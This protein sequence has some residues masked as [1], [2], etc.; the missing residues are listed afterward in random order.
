MNLTSCIR[1]LPAAVLLCGLPAVSVPGATVIANF[2]GGNGTGSVDAYAGTAGNGWFGAWSTIGSNG[3]TVSASVATT[4]PLVSGS[5]NYLSATVNG[6][7]TNAANT[8]AYT[9]R[10]LDA[11]VFDYAQPI[12]ISFLFR[13]DSAFSSG[14]S[15]FRIMQNAPGVT[16]G[17]GP[18]NLWVISSGATAAPTWN[19]GGLS[20]PDGVNQNFDS[21]ITV[22]AGHVYSFSLLLDMT[23]K[24]YVATVLDLNT[25]ASFTT[26]TIYFRNQGTVTNTALEFGALLAASA[27]TTGQSMTFSVDGISVSNIPEP[28][29]IALLAGAAAL[30]AGLGVRRRRTRTASV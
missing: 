3:A 17:T 2:D 29:T 27:S 15:Q 13:P 7:G 28:S 18:S 20:A 10:V 1:H 9:G 24:S 23:E 21:G 30:T 26:G 19:F 16:N 25:S 6:S 12:E 14:S 11:S 5:G 8:Q 4:S 22:V